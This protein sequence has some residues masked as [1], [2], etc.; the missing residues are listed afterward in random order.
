[1]KLRAEKFPIRLLRPFRIA[2]GVS[3]TRDTLLVHLEDGPFT[4]H[5]EGA[6]PPYYPST[7]EAGLAWLDGLDLR[8]P[9]PPAPPEAAAARVAVEMALCDLE[10]QRAGEPLWKSWGLD[11]SRIPPCPTTLSI[12]ESEAE[13]HEM[14]GE[15]ISGGATVLK[16]KSGSGDSDWDLRCA[17]I[18]ARRQLPFSVDAN[19]G[20]SVDTAAALIPKL[21]DFGIEFVEQPVAKDLAA[22]RELKNKLRER[23]IPPLVADE[24]L[25]SD[26]D[27]RTFAKV[28]DG[29]NIKILKAGGLTA[30]RRWIALARSLKLK[31]MI[32]VMV[33]TGIGRTAAAHL[34]PAADWLDI[35]PPSSIPVA[36]LC[37][38]EIAGGKLSISN[39]PGLGLQPLSG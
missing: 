3:T 32:G 20:W 16:L 22:W 12:P 27:L 19:A 13:L 30:A 28:A 24:S 29:V 35:D 21:Q 23:P 33:E 7:A 4:G 25:Q 31:V 38:F 11:P 34:A 36:P 8:A 17:K 15:A 18:V 2:H 9:L 1:M 26:D 6:L 14:L 39:R 10:A 5:G 37:G